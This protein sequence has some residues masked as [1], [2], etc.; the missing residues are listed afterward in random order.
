MKKIKKIGK[1]EIFADLIGFSIKPV[2][3]ALRNRNKQVKIYQVVKFELMKI[4]YSRVRF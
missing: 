1:D 3:L 4:N 2:K